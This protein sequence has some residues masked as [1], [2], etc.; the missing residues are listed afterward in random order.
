MTDL[1]IAAQR[2]RDAFEQ[3]LAGYRAPSDLPERARLG[4]L[5]RARRRRARRAACVAAIACAAAASVVAGTSAAGPGRGRPGPASPPAAVPPRLLPAAKSAAGLPS[6]AAVSRAMLTSFSAASG[7]ILYE[8]FIDTGPGGTDEDQYWFWPAQ[9]V[10][11]Q[12]VRE[13]GLRVLHYSSSARSQQPTEDWATAYTSPVHPP[14][15]NYG[16]TTSIQ[17]TMVCYP[18]GGGCGWG[19]TQT[20]GRTWSTVRFQ[21]QPEVS[22]IS[23]GG[24]VNP[25]VLARAIAQRQWRVVSRTRLGGQQAIELSET[26]AGPISPLPVELWVNAQTY[27][28]LRCDGS[29]F[30]EVF[31]YLP[32]TVVNLALLQVPIPHGFPRSDPF[33]R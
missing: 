21:G 32:P 1:D 18:P 19:P 20:P 26:A 27:L 17:L 33:S 25:A 11:G 16:F 8:R 14:P 10:P 5:R 6:A 7:D 29:G 30:S 13:R 23:A 22:D 24:S 9:P 4:G 12:K 15:A 3:D 2:I 31:G 28:P